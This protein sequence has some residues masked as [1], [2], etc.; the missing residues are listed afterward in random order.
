MILVVLREHQRQRG[1]LHVVIRLAEQHGWRLTCQHAR[2]QL[3]LLEIGR[4]ERAFDSAPASP[5]TP[6]AATHLESK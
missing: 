4:I 1:R 3:R 5:T 6:A 2:E